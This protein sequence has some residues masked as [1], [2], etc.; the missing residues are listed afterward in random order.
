MCAKVVAVEWR[1]GMT[2]LDALNASKKPYGIE[3]HFTGVGP[4]AFVTEIDGQA[5]DASGNWMYWVN[6]VFANVGCGEF[7]L[8]HGDIV[9]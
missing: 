5:N 3:F 8:K 6:G 7:E 4:D 2:V 1:R 9:R